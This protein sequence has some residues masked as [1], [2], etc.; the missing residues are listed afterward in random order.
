MA[1]P[2]S[3]S[4]I[5]PA[6]NEERTLEPSINTVLEAVRNNFSEY[7]IIIFNDGSTDRTGIIADSLAA[8]NKNITVVHHNK[9]ICIGGVYKKGQKSARMEYLILVNGKNDISVSALNKI[10]ALHGK[11]DI[12]IPY[13]SNLRERSFARRIIAKVFVALLNA[14]FRLKIKY[15]NHFVLHRR[16]IVNSIDI[17]TNSYAYQAEALIKLIKSGYSYVEVGVTGIFEKDTETKA[18]RIRNILEV[19]LFFMRL[20]IQSTLKV[21]E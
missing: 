6:L 19:G 5:I 16:S 14:I 13:L 11:Y 7:E 4:V 15:Y 17:R 1:K 8:Q 10:F 2:D 3:I 20:I 12:I 9:S 21:S 18:F